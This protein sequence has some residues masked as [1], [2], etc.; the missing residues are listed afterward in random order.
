M[1]KNLVRFGIL[2]FL[3]VVF[4][5]FFLRGVEWKEVFGYLTDVKR[6]FF[7]LVILLVPFHFVAR[8]I[9]W[10]YLLKHEKKTKLF[11]R[12]A[13][14][15]IGST[16]T[17]IFPGR[18]GELARPLYLAQKENMKTGFVIGTVV[19]ERVFDI[20]TMCTL[21]GLFLITRPFYSSYFQAKEEVYS[22][23]QFWGSVAI[24]VASILFL[25]ILA[26]I[27]F[28][29]K[30]LAIF[31]F[32][33]K[34]LP[35]KTSQKIIEFLEEFVKGLKFFHS[36]GNLL[37]YILLSFGVWLSIIF[38]Y[39]IFL[40]AYNISVPL[41]SLIPYTFLVMIG[42]SIPTP[43]MAG[44]F[45]FFSREGLTSLFSVNLNQAVAMTIVVHAIQL[46]MTCLIGYVILWKEG[47]SLLQIKKLGEDVES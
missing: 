43:G 29:E 17:F 21:L 26:F 16:V 32:F 1:K 5:Y 14:L 12:F 44:G 6:E 20:F 10:E 7:I 3:T 40:F 28:R 39:W 45:H 27:F 33:L 18:L 35:Q 38:Y 9:R 47:I 13:G 34:P 23:L 46:V 42:A 15:A 37:M 2:F 25:F 30:T 11:S 22:N 8:A 19:V 24:I 41:F 4:L 36:A 31:S